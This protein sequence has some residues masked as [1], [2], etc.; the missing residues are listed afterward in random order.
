MKKMLVP[1]LFFLPTVLA[2]SAQD[3]TEFKTINGVP[4][5][6]NPAKPLH[7]TIAVEVERFF[8]R[9][10]TGNVILYDPNYAEGH[11]FGPDGKYLGLLTKIGQGPGEFST[12]QGYHVSFLKSDIWVYGGRK[13][14][15]LDGNGIYREERLLK[16]SYYGGLEGGDFFTEDTKWNE[17]K[18]STRTLKFIRCAMSG[19]EQT[20]DLLQAENIGMIRNPS[21]NGGFSDSWGTP[22]FFYSGDP[23]SK[24]IYCGLH[25]EYL[26]RVKDYQ[27]KDLLFIRKPYEYVKVGRA[28]VGKLI[29]WAL[30][31]ERSKWILSAYPDRLIAIKEVLPLP[32]GHLAVY[33]V[34]GIQKVEIDVFDAQ[35]R[36][37][38]VLA[39]SSDLN[40]DNLKFLP[41]G[42]ATIEPSGDYSVYR[43]YRIKNLPEIFGR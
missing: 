34:S 37:L 31:E 22:G 8:S 29:P 28:D 18:V 14:A 40:T 20:V 41:F 27:G 32:K 2:F 15:R 4:H 42:F 3:K 25:T 39:F 21:G 30:K 35:G 16:S 6:F 12:Q 38:Y 24:R 17:N 5:A 23:N 36:Y 1:I 11:R 26:I 19:E 9:D 7:G 13:A 10:E 43:E 33:R